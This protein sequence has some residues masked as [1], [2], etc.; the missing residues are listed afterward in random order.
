MKIS[1]IGAGNIG[2][3]LG[4]KWAAQGHEVV[5]GVRDLEAERVRSL[6]EKFGH[7]ATADGMANALAEAEVVLFAIP[8]SAM[9]ETVLQLGSKLNGK[10][11]ID[12]TNSVG[13]SPMHQL[14]L[15]RQAAPDSPLFRAFST[16][17]WENFAEPLMGGAQIDLFYCGASETP[18]AV[19]DKLISEIGLRPVHIGGL[20]KAGI[21][22][23]LTQLWFTLALEQGRGRRLALKMM[24]E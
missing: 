15:L 14:D 19:V 23:A 5:F 20:D 2:G 4:G 16:L 22:D 17:G 1:V 21:V 6:L 9:P 11:L 8:G 10:I 24:T 18:Q 12:A 13:K 3:T 7:G